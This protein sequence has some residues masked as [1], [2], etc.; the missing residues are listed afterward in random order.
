MKK[1]LLLVILI[2]IAVMPVFSQ[3]EP[4]FSIFYTIGGGTNL[5]LE[6]V[7]LGIQFWSEFSDIPLNLLFEANGS[8][9]RKD[10][11]DKFS[12]DG[13]PFLG[14]NY[15]LGGLV[16]YRI[17]QIFLLGAGGG[18]GGGKFFYQYSYSYPYIRG[19]ASVAFGNGFLKLGL[20]YDYGFKYGSMYGLRFHV[21]PTKE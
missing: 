17:E 6:F 21:C 4:H 7:A 9:V 3:A 19:S 18:I 11:G 10:K 15:H 1:Y 16:E 8:I 13:G 14:L 20:Y 12:D 5:G 2:L